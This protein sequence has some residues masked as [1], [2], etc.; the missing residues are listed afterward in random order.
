[1]VTT[2]ATASG[3]RLD[4][5]TRTMRT[6]QR[7]ATG[8]TGV[9]AALYALLYAGVL[10]LPGANDGERGILGVAAAVFAMLAVALWRYRGRLLWSAAVLLQLGLGWMYLAIAPER[11][12]S[13][14]VWGLT[15]RALSIPLVVTL[16]GLLVLHHRDRAQRRR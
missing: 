3:V 2:D 16:V 7:V 9:I 5:R 8:L 13:F 1:M 4:D 14:E 12:P 15:I 10:E 6:L 11:D